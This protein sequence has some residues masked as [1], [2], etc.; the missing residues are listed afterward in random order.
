MKTNDIFDG[1]KQNYSKFVKLVT[2][3]LNITRT[4]EVLEI[5]TAL[6]VRTGTLEV[7]R[8]SKADEIVDIF[9]SNK[10]TSEKINTHCGLVWN[11][12]AFGTDTPKYFISPRLFQ[13]TLLR[14]KRSAMDD[15]SNMS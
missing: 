11:D 3:D 10:S 9:K 7:K 4:T 15:A 2:R 12:S 8:I 1:K 5:S 6:D 13:R 14:S